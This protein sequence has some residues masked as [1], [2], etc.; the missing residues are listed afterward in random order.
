MLR[1]DGRVIDQHAAAAEFFNDLTNQSFRKRKIADVAAECFGA[2]AGTADF[3]GG[4]GGDGV[5]D[6][7]DSDGC[8]GGSEC[9]CHRPADAAAEPVIRATFPDIEKSKASMRRECYRRS[10]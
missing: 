3:I 4:F 10:E 8:A 5:V 6:I 1:L 7:L 2:A 9:G